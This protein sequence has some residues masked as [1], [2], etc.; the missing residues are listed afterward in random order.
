MRNTHKFE[1]II[2]IFSDKR[3]IENDKDNQIHNKHDLNYLF[4]TLEYERK[5][6]TTM[7]IDK[8]NTICNTS[9]AI[10]ILF[11]KKINR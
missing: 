3:K 8:S 5:N 7:K 11:L 1:A 6:E 9:R 4:F 10:C 2:I